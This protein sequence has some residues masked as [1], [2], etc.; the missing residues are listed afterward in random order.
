MISSAF[1][2]FTKKGRNEENLGKNLGRLLG[3]SALI[4]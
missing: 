3:P 1:K 2:L 4:F